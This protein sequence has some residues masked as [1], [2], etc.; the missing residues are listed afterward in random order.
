VDVSGD[1]PFPELVGRARDAVL[2]LFE[3]QDIP[4]MK[5]RAALFPDFPKQGDYARTAAV[6][7][8]EL[9]YFHAA[10]DHWAPGSGVVE[11][12]GADDAVDDIFFRG[13]LQP[14]SITFVD[15]GSRMWG[16][17]SYKVDFYDD[18]TIERLASAI[19]SMLTSAAAAHR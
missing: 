4:F 13:Q 3:H 9:L 15:D 17:I 12:P 18:T 16:H 14:L 7:P 19:E 6:I 1:P 10:H 2:G 11:R 5:V 8:V